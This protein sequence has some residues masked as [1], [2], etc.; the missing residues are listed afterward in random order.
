M[1]HKVFPLLPPDE[2]EAPSFTIKG[3]RRERKDDGE[4]VDVEFSQDFACLDVQPPGF[5]RD[6]A[7]TAARLGGWPM[8]QMLLY[9]EGCLVEEDETRFRMLMKD[10]AVRI[11]ASVIADISE[12]LSEHY[13]AR[14]TEPPSSSRGGRTEQPGTSEDESDSQASTSTD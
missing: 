10:K 4:V 8:A 9:I 11:H 6:Y 14:P 1:S 3:T 5:L 13:N 7:M 12:F 2:V